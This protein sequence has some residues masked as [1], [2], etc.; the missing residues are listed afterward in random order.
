MKGVLILVIVLVTN[1]YGYLPVKYGLKVVE[2]LEP[3]RSDVRLYQNT[4]YFV[5]FSSTNKYPWIL[6]GTN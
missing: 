3:Q 4:R 1:S 6:L 2:E 5:A